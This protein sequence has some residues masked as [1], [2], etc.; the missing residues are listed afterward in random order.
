MQT[1]R[2]FALTVTNVHNKHSQILL[3]KVLNYKVFKELALYDIEFMMSHEHPIAIVTY[4][5]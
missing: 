1:C 4:I 5:Q 2:V 3:Y